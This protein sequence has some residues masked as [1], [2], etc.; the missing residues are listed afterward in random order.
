[1]LQDVQRGALGRQHA[2]RRAGDP[3]QHLALGGTR[4]V[5]HQQFDL[6]LRHIAGEYR[7]GHID[8]GDHHG[9]ARVDGELGGGVLGDDDL[10]GEVAKADVFHQRAFDEGLDLQAVYHL[11]CLRL[12]ISRP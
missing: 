6:A 5:F 1:M 4:A 2:A 11:W 12:K 7:A 8:A 10:G 9:V 3:H